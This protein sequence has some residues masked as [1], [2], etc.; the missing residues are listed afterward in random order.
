MHAHVRVRRLHALIARVRVRLRVRACV[1]C[2]RRTH[3]RAACVQACSVHGMGACMRVESCTHTRV[4]AGRGSGRAAAGGCHKNG[5]EQ[6]SASSKQPNP[7]T[8]ITT[9]NSGSTN[10]AINHNNH[11]NNLVNKTRHSKNDK[12]DNNNNNNH[13]S[14]DHTNINK[15][16]RTTRT[17]RRTTRVIQFLHL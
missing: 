16:K 12:N 14:P 6:R 3:T 2:V 7:N 10:W 8:T 1:L 4:Q 5:D 17:K 9:R 15:D 13:Q 11:N